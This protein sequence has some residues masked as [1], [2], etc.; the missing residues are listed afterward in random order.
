MSE[1]HVCCVRCDVRRAWRATVLCAALRSRD[2]IVCPCYQLCYLSVSMAMADAVPPV[3]LSHYS[4]H[5][6]KYRTRGTNNQS[7]K[8]PLIRLACDRLMDLHSRAARWAR[9]SRGYQSAGEHG[10]LWEA[11][12]GWVP[13]RVGRGLQLHFVA[14]LVRRV[15]Q[16]GSA[17][18]D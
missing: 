9:A 5:Y 13:I 18:H 6:C 3:G 2:P 15:A 7:Q 11:G 8:T 10:A 4:S 16:L 1:L 12:P 17:Q 14:Y